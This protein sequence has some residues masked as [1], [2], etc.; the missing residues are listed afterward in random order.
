MDS[1]KPSTT[2]SGTVSIVLAWMVLC[3]AIHLI[4]DWASSLAPAFD[5]AKE[6]VVFLVVFLAAV[7]LVL[8]FVRLLLRLHRVPAEYKTEAA[9]DGPP[10]EVQKDLVIVMG[11]LGMSLVFCMWT[12]LVSVSVSV[13]SSFNTPSL[14]KSPCSSA[15]GND[16][17][18]N[19]TLV[20]DDSQGRGRDKENTVPIFVPAIRLAPTPLLN[21]TVPASNAHGQKNWMPPRGI[22]FPW[23][24]GP[25]R[26]TA[27]RPAPF[28]AFV[29]EFVPRARLVPGTTIPGPPGETHYQLTPHRSAAPKYWSSRSSSGG[30]L[31]IVSP[32]SS[33]A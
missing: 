25:T 7:F 3:T 6:W 27:P 19:T 32:S 31:S 28:T 1:Y 12:S 9:H 22:P 10:R 4:V 8:G 24:R 16:D 20:A 14:A 29:P 5:L 33:S 11:Y 30:P 17:E 23:T 13:Y 15:D 26:M 21:D 2:T 18:G